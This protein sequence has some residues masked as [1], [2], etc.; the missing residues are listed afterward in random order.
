MKNIITLFVVLSLATGALFSIDKKYVPNLEE[1]NEIKYEIPTD[2]ENIKYPELA[3]KQFDLNV[4]NKNNSTQGIRVGDTLFTDRSTWTLFSSGISPIV[5]DPASETASFILS[6]R[7]F[8]NEVF[9]GFQSV[10]YNRTSMGYDTAVVFPSGPN[11]Q[12]LGMFPSLGVANF[13]GGQSLADMAYA[14]Y[15]P[16]YWVADGSGG[17]SFNLQGGDFVL[18]FPGAGRFKQTELSPRDGS[19]QHLQDWGTLKMSSNFLAGNN[20]VF[21]WNITRPKTE[22]D[23]YGYYGFW[24]FD[25]ENEFDVSTVPPAFH[26][27]KFRSSD[28]INSSWQSPMEIDVD[29]EGTFY[30]AVNNRFIF[31]PEPRL[32]GVSKSSN[33]GQTWTDFEALPE[34]ALNSFLAQYPEYDRYF[35]PQ[36]YQKDAFIVT[37]INQYS[38]IYRVYMDRMGSQDIEPRLSLV[39]A[40]FS[41]GSWTLTEIA[42]LESFGPS[43]IVNDPDNANQNAYVMYSRS[44]PMGNNVRVA[45]TQDN[46]EII[47]SFI[48]LNLDRNLTLPRTETIIVEQTDEATGDRIKVPQQITEVMTTDVYIARRPMNGN[49]WTVVNVTND[50][51]YDKVFFIPAVVKSATEIDAVSATTVNITNTQHPLFPVARVLQEQTIDLSDYNVTHRF[52]G[53]RGPSSVKGFTE[54]KASLGDAYPNPAM[55]YDNVQITYTLDEAAVVSL[56]I[57]DTFGNKV[58]SIFSNKPETIGLHAVNANLG[59]IASG[60]YYYTLTVG[61][62]KVT[63]LLNVVR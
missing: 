6:N 21:G 11:P 34:S 5:Y 2:F 10:I 26:T 20:T 58:K 57:F 50:D 48:D 40:K 47:V 15:I 22:M 44:S 4:S 16:H 62:E 59:N 45:R 3:P 39:E 14:A 8:V 27:D 33:R 55:S 43:Y 13:T 1:M 24:L 61:T 54:Y 19:P 49:T 63:K 32:V 28:A 25:F 60:S 53:T 17:Y 42:E 9:N 51:H 41:A 23:Q 12:I 56:D 18:N 30:A 46:D 37:G 52:D 36:P 29:E 38:Y 35:I 7:V 31:N